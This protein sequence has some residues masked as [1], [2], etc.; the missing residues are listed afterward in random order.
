VSDVVDR[1][2]G[3]TAERPAADGPRGQDLIGDRLYLLA[4]LRSRVAEVLFA[5]DYPYWFDE[6]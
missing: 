1:S 6:P 5:I 4:P 3:H 2:A